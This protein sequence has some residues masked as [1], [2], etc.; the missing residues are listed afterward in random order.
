[1]FTIENQEVALRKDASGV[2]RVGKSRVTL[3]LVIYEFNQGETPEEI[4]MHYPSVKLEDVYSVVSYYLN[5]RT[6]VDAYLQERKKH[7]DQIR[8]EINAR[9][10]VQEL[11][12][13]LLARARARGLR[14][15]ETRGG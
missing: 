15:H 4:A 3:D 2:L 14:M 8:Q 1:M 6:R 7:A 5:N 13:K 10:E 12:R 11:R 9:P